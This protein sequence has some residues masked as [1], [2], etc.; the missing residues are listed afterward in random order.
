VT[1]TIVG[2]CGSCGAPNYDT[3]FCES[4][5]ARFT[6]AGRPD[7]A[8]SAASPAIPARIPAAVVGAVAPLSIPAVL[9]LVFGLLGGTL[10]AII[11]GHLALSQIA[12]TGERG[13]G[14]ALAGTILGYLS[15]VTSIVIVIV[16]VLAGT[17]HVTWG[18]GVR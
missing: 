11:L 17:S 4:C 18:F 3:R 13:H 9:A 15:S 5:G 14:M 16:I 7:A 6:A 10:V 1:D 2:S 12:R 8:S